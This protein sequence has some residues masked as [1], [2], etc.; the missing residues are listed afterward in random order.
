MKHYS[1]H[2]YVSDS[3]DEL[4]TIEEELEAKGVTTP[5]IHMVSLNDMDADYHPRLHQVSSIGKTDTLYGASR[6]AVVG[7]LA[8]GALLSVIAMTGVTAQTGWF[9]FIMAALLIFGFC[10]WEGGLFGIQHNNH[11][12]KQFEDLLKQGKHVFFVDVSA[13]QEPVL[14]EVL[15]HHPKLLLAGDGDAGS[16]ALMAAKIQLHRMHKAFP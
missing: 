6:G 4:E 16:D 8:A 13:D 2:F 3:L 12:F 9:P 1:R 10:T 5:Q 11:H 7:V 14:G 15:Q